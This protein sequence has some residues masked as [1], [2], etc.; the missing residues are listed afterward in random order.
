MA[1]FPVSSTVMLSEHLLLILRAIVASRTAVLAICANARMI[2]R[3]LLVL[4]LLGLPY[5]AVAQVS[6]SWVGQK[7]V[8]KYRPPVKAKG[9]AVD[10]VDYHVFTVTQVKG[11]QLRLKAGSIERSAPSSQV[12]LLD[13]A[14][15]FYTQEIKAKSSNSTAWALRGIVWHEK[16]DYDKAIADFNE[17]VRIVPSSSFAYQN[18]GSAWRGKR[19]YDRAIADY[20]E[21][22]RLAPIEAHTYYGR[23][24]AR[25]NKKE[26]DKAIADFK[27]AIRLDPGNEMAR[28]NRAIAMRDKKNQESH[29]K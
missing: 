25:L 12:L 16:H 1:H 24:F 29:S 17:V 7:V 6:C 22:T 23:G 9:R 4:P 20:T 15:R 13:Q 28:K 5:Q 2:K 27:E 8:L 21:A 26:Y 14:I 11:D 3:L 10:Q 19:E 18:R